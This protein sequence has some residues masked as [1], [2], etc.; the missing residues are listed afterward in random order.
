MVIEAVN[1][2]LVAHQMG[3]FHAEK[4]IELLEI[5]EDF[6]PISVTAIGYQGDPKNLSADLYKS[7]F[8]DRER[9]SLN[10]LVFSGKFGAISQLF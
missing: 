6:N 10:E 3:G 5:P 1:Q 9:H 4:I 8:R 2:G 7:E